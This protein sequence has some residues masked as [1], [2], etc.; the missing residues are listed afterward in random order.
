MGAGMASGKLSQW[1]RY[2]TVAS[3]LSLV[4]TEALAA[5]GAR[6]TLVATVA[7]FGFV[8]PMIFGMAYLLVPSFVGRTLADYRLPGLH[9]GLAYLGTAGLVTGRVTGVDPITRGGVVAWSLGV[10]LFVGIL[11]WTTV[12]AIRER[13]AVVLRSGDRPQRSSRLATAMIPVTFGYLL[14][15]TAGLLGWGGFGPLPR[16]TFPSVIHYYGAGLGALLIFA[17]GARLMPGFFH[18]TPPRVGTWVTLVPGAVAPGLLA[19]SLWTGIGFRAGAVLQT[20]AMAG[21]AGLVGYVFWQSEWHRVGLYG[22][23]LGAIAGIVAVGINVPVAF[24]TVV[25]GQ[26]RAHA[27][28]MI[29]GFFALTIVG[30]AMQFF[31][32]TSGRFPGATNRTV[33]GTILALALGTLLEASGYLSGIA[34]VSRGGAVLT[35]CGAVVYTYLMGRRLLGD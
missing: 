6:R 26:L 8:C 12:P 31:A 2:F 10:V 30:Y 25:P 22:I 1:T 29:S 15:G 32:V 28:G 20:V 9:F 21:Y 35:L 7:V 23:L 11:A 16:V 13:P 17:L 24:G 33:L 27:T 19:T 18:V 3:A 5:V 14:V 34:P 4:G